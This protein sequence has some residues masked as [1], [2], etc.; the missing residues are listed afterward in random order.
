MATWEMQLLSRVIR[1]GDLSTVTGWGVGPDDFLTSEGRGIF[2][3]VV[4]Y[5]S[6]PG[7]AGSVIGINS[8]P[9]YFPNFVLCDDPS[10]TTDALCRQVRRD[11]LNIQLKQQT[12]RA[13]DLIDEDPMSAA[14]YLNSASRDVMNLGYSQTT[15]IRG[16]VGA[17]KVATSYS[18]R[19]Q[20]IDLSV[21]K[22]AWPILNDEMGGI[23][24]DDYVVF[25]GRPKSFKSWIL[26]VTVA[27]LI[28]AG[29]RVLLYTKEMTWEQMMERVIAYI[30]SVRY[31]NLL[32]GKLNYEEETSF[33]QTC[34]LL[35]MPE[36]SE[37]FVC[38]SGMD[39]NGHDTIPWLH[40]KIE[41]YKPHAIAVDGLHLM[42][43]VHKAR[44]REERI[45]NISRDMRAM[46]I[47]TRVPCIATVQAN[48]SAA[49]HQEANTDEVA[50]S[51]AIG[52]DVTALIRT[53]KNKREN[54]DDPLTVSLVV[55]AMRNG[56]LEG[57]RINA[58][59]ATDFS[60][61]S[62]LTAVDALNAKDQDDKMTNEDGKKTKN[63]ASK[64]MTEGLAADTGVRVARHTIGK[65]AQA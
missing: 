59:P 2:N 5:H 61:H 40:S 33:D 38:L 20:G 36:I 47:G 31:W 44:K 62:K 4:S 27:T 56:D 64:Q 12:S 37:H 17:N 3:L 9:M 11:R 48:R 63:G 42:S 53:I 50:Y 49:K 13:L 6:H 41:S 10:M 28:M 52:Q 45:T 39:A 26:V 34:M 7:S 32:H 46:V 8:M 19:R 54:I 16:A 14:Q 58:V 22:W 23:R 25:F 43:D 60:F 51:D 18:L 57:F 35:Q 65:G 21:G 15:D 55:G 24:D 29:K 1:T 30:A